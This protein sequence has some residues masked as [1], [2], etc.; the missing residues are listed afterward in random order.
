VDDRHSGGAGGAL[1]G[2]SSEVLTAA[3]FHVD[4]TT[5][6][7]TIQEH[8]LSVSW[9]YEVVQTA[10]QVKDGYALLS[11]MSGLGVELNEAEAARHPYVAD[12]LSQQTF[13]DGA[14]ADV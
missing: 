2:A 6:N 1:H 12:N 14:V 9:R 4:A 11:N 13:A 8:P 10:W 7:C 5:P 3:N